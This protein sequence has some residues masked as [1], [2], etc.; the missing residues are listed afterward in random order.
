METGR[1]AVPSSPITFH[2]QIVKIQFAQGNR[3]AE[4]IKKAT[5]RPESMQ[6]TMLLMFFVQ[7]L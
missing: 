2:H 6:D 1:M 7:Y 4:E 3:G 5:E